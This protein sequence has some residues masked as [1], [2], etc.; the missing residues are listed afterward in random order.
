MRFFAVTIK[1]FSNKCY[2]VRS[3]LLHAQLPYP[4]AHL[5]D[6]LLYLDSLLDGPLLGLRVHPRQ[7]LHALDELVPH[8]LDHL[9]RLDREEDSDRWVNLI[10]DQI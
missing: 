10:H 2:P 4:S 8:T 9:V 3:W 1:G 7:V 6:H 5:T